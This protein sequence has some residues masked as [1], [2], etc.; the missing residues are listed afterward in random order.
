MV[1][2]YNRREK[3]NGG[4]LAPSTL[5]AATSLRTE[6]WDTYQLVITWLCRTT[7]TCS[8]TEFYNIFQIQLSDKVLAL[9]YIPWVAVMI[10]KR[11]W[12]KACCGL[13]CD[14]MFY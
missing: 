11:I 2:E 13:D 7:A 4:T 12:L 5:A 1:D 10:R 6:Y 9:K 8:I 14:I 3:V